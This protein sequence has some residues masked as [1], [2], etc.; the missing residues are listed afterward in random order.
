MVERFELKSR[1][2]FRDLIAKRK[3]WNQLQGHL[4]SDLPY[5]ELV[6]PYW[7]RHN[8]ALE[9][10][11][12]GSDW[13]NVALDSK[14]IR[15]LQCHM[16]A[17]Q[18]F[19]ARASQDTALHSSDLLQLHAIL[20]E[21][22]QP[23]GGYYRVSADDS[24]VEVGNSADF[25]LIPDLV[26]SAFDWFH[27]DSFGEMHEVERAALMLIRL[28]DIHPFDRENGK[29]IRLFS[30]Y[31]LLK[32]GYPP[33]IIRSEQALVYAQALQEALQF[34]TGALVKLLTEAV[35]ESLKFCLGEDRGSP[36]LVILD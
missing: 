1:Q 18:W 24:M 27:A 8:C 15:E 6:G 22:L 30:N 14:K 17:S 20:T 33:A 21:N 25:E 9:E 12:P 28:V 35:M 32:A 3:R 5:E 19:L 31:F 36:R 16:H 4:K 23:Q 13:H 29:T 7:G 26:E 2:H 34:R 10:V 11:E